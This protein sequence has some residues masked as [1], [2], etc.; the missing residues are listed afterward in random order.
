MNFTNKNTINS[1]LN[2][3][4]KVYDLVKT[5]SFKFIRNYNNSLLIKFQAIEFIAKR[6][7]IDLNN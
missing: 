1:Y 6:M 2:E 5:H 4:E 7:Q 3:M